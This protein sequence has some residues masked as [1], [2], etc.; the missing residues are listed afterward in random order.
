MAISIGYSL[1]S[2]LGGQVGQRFG[3]QAGFAAS[4]FV[5]VVGGLLM[6]ALQ[7]LPGAAGRPASGATEKGPR[8]SRE[9]FR[10]L[11]SLPAP[12]WM[13]TLIAV[14]INLAIETYFNFY[15]LY[16]LT[17][18]ISLA[19]ISTIKSAHSLAATSVRFGAVW[20]LHLLKIDLLNHGLV[21][22]TALGLAALSVAA[23]GAGDPGALRDSRRCARPAARHQCDHR[24]GAQTRA[25]G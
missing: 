17:I 12:V 8:L 4:G 3:Y 18:G 9:M 14:Y 20:L 1:G 25:T 16:A 21:I 5:G 24:R 10:P 15:P 6:L 2:P 19:A 7:P 23:R 13:A 22:I 11:L